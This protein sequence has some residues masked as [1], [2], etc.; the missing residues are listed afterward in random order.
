MDRMPDDGRIIVLPET[1]TTLA[2]VIR[3]EGGFTVKEQKIRIDDLL[4]ALLVMVEPFELT[5][6]IMK[7]G[8]LVGEVLEPAIEN[9]Q[10]DSLSNVLNLVVRKARE[11]D[12]LAIISD[13]FKVVASK[14][15]LSGSVK[16][17]V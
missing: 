13:L 17:F 16:Y 14:F 1:D 2:R 12:D 8:D 4:N 6:L 9:L 15:D 5:N 10:G 11:T 3:R 7:N